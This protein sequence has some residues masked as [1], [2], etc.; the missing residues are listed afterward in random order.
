MVERDRNL[1]CVF[2]DDDLLCSLHKAHGHAFIP[3]SCQAYPFGFQENETGRPVALLSRYCPSIRDNRGTDI[4]PL[5]PEKLEQAGGARPLAPSM[6]L[7]SGR[8]LPS[9]QFAWLVDAWREVLARMPVPQA[10]V[11]LFEATDRFDEALAAPLATR[12]PALVSAAWDAAQQGPTVELTA[13]RRSFSARILLAYLLGGLS[14]PSR[15]LLPHRTGKSTLL[16]RLRALANRLAWLAGW[17]SV[18]LYLV[19]RAVPL[20]RLGRVGS[21][22]RGPHSSIVAEYLREVLWRRQGLHRK[23]YLHRILVDLALMAVVIAQHAKAAAA[24]RSDNEASEADVREAIGVAELLFSH[25]SDQA[26][27]PVL[28]TLRLKLLSDERH[29]R[30]LLA[31][32]L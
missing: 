16:E 6:G 3:A 8:V 5:L 17:G 27:G 26:E 9:E 10:L 14:Y 32:E 19:P 25:Q 13:R 4:A 7:R 11:Q 20:R 22:L 18:D 21:V 28:S 24:S 29:F 23:T 2:L 30:Q 15:V 12:S 1:R 31:A